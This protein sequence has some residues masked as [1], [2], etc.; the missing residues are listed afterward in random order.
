VVANKLSGLVIKRENVIAKLENALAVEDKTGTA[1]TR[2]T[3][4]VG[5]IP[6]VGSAAGAIP[7]LGSAMTGE[8][9]NSIECESAKWRV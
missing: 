2:S 3:G 6:G 1:P 8:R 5:G 7:V 9:V 4:L